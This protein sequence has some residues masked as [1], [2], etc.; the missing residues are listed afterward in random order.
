MKKQDHIR[1]RFVRRIKQRQNWPTSAEIAL[2]NL[3][4]AKKRMPVC[5][6]LKE[7]QMFVQQV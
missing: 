1:H 6:G 7:G 4:D 5:Q 3:L 2:S